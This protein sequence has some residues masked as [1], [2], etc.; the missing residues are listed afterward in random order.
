MQDN[1]PVTRQ[2][3]L[4]EKQKMAEESSS[5]SSPAR[6]NIEALPQKSWVSHLHKSSSTPVTL[7]Q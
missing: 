1:F 3:K 5:C 4:K 7:N 2:L 6:Q